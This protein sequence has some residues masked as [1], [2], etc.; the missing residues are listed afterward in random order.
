MSANNPSRNSS[1]ELLRIIAIIGVIVLHYNNASMG[2]GFQ[3]VQA[4]SANYY[5]L[6][7]TESI[8]I[9]AVNLFIA[10]SGYFL[11]ETTERRFVKVIELLL[12][13]II[14][15]L[16]FYFIDIITTDMV[17]SKKG[18]LE[19][20]L[21][22]NYFVLLYL[23]LYIISPYI[24]LLLNRLSKRNFQKLCIT[25]FILFS[26][27]TMGTDI[28]ANIM[29]VSSLS[30][31][32]TISDVGNLSGCTIVNFTLMYLLGAYIKRFQISLT[33]KKTLLCIVISVCLIFGFAVLERWKNWPR[34]SS[35][36]YNN[37]VV[38]LLAVFVL[39][40]FLNFHFQSK[41]INELAKA[42]FTAY[43][44]H[45][46][47]LKYCRIEQFVQGSIWIMIL[48]QIACSVALFLISYVVYKLYY[49]CTHWFIRLIT[50]L[51][52]K[53]KLSV[54]SD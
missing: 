33:K 26:V 28:L 34:T 14:F 7:F 12:Q 20:F 23:T 37:P 38:V 51:C 32:S 40:F 54:S 6:V 35:W 41:I 43:L 48:H 39:L 2:G 52:D 3:Y 46:N 25:A 31:L 9:C 5:Y 36:G 19:A 10:I 30:G 53:V 13:V 1:I 49:L 22:R 45:L 50:P 42:A 29:G 15:R 11:S 47:T 16:I 21:P 24:N 27:W 8:C 18:L 4:G 17:F 44:F